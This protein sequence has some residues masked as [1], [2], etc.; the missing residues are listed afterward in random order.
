MSTLSM[1]DKRKAFYLAVTSFQGSEA[2]WES[3]AQTGLNNAELLEALR[4]EIGIAGGR[5]GCRDKLNVSY[6]GAGLKIWASRAGRNCVVSDK[7]ILQGEATLKMARE[8]FSIA[9]PDEEQLD[10]FA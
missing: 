7:P 9:N 1:E 4:Y 8:V 3:R 2:R 6:Q 10:L 5:S